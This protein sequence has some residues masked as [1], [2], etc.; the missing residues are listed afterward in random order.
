MKTRKWYVYVNALSD[1]GSRMDL[2]AFSALIFTFENS[3]M[4]LTA[5]F[6]ARQVGGLLFSLAAGVVADRFDRR[7]AMIASDLGSGLA[8]AAVVLFPHPYTVVAAAFVKG[9]LFSVFQISFRASMPKL[10]PGEGLAAV[11]G[12]IVRLEAVAG[13]IGFVLGGVASDLFGHIWVIGFDAATFF[14]SALVLVRLRW[15]SY[16]AA[17]RHKRQRV[18]WIKD[19]QEGWS[20]LRQNDVLL[21][22]II[23]SFFWTVS[24]AAYNY[25]LPLL[26][27]MSVRSHASFHGLMWSLL[28]VG[29]LVGAWLAPRLGWKEFSAL[30]I[31]LL[32]MAIVISLAF[33]GWHQLI[34]LLLLTV[35]GVLEGWREVFQRT[36]VQ[37]ADNTV[38][39]RA[40]GMQT[41]LTRGGFFLG[42]LLSP[43][44]FQAYGLF[45]MVAVSQAVLLLAVSGTY[46]FARKKTGQG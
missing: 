12:L 7:K 9:I 38:R 31:S 24:V 33:A 2:I 44:I 42:F 10:F 15:D 13:M 23:L 11:N 30:S 26:A 14:A 25:G 41:L 40:L 3:A 34:I 5:F 46:L 1:L 28:S 19:L 22:V 39:G 45:A 29:T 4:W 37:Q 43:M 20:Y 16:P 36:I 8:I 35:T 6:L 27:E 17:T 21:A 32:A 18:S